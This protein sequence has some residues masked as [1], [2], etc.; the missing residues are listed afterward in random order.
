MIIV[1]SV[2]VLSIANRIHADVST[3]SMRRPMLRRRPK[4]RLSHYEPG[5]RIFLHASSGPRAHLLI[6][7]SDSTA[8]V[9]DAMSVSNHPTTE[10]ISSQQVEL[11][12][13]K[14]PQV[15][16]LGRTWRGCSFHRVHRFRFLRKCNNREVTLIRA[17]TNTNWSVTRAHSGCIAM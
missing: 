9:D 8:P 10:A 12:K 5:Q 11:M 1:Q 6:L 17:C 7:P 15:S 2:V 14:L 16:L 13:A 4:L 3:E